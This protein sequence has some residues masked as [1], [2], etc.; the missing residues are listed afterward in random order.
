MASRIY[1]TVSKAKKALDPLYKS[2]RTETIQQYESM[3]KKN[4]E[5]VVKDEVA[6]EKLAKQWFYTKMSKIPAGI[7]HSEK[8]L[9]GQGQIQ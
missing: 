5:Y 7:E 2:A 4:A 6:A 1:Q 3:M 8:E 9:G